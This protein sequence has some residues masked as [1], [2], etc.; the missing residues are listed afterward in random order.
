MLLSKRHKKI[1]KILVVVAS[2]ALLATSLLPL[3]YSL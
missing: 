1:W 3:F 2:A